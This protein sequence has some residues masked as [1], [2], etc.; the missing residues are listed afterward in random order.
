LKIFYVDLG[1]DKTESENEGEKKKTLE[2]PGI[3]S[4]QAE[5]ILMVS[6]YSV[7]HAQYT[8]YIIRR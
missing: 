4:E 7:R 3:V 6:V 2:K 5:I 8:D 1:N